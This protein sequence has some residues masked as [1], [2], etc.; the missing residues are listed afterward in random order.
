[1]KRFFEFLDKFLLN[2]F[3]KNV[4]KMPERFIKIIAYYHPDPYIRKIYYEKL[5]VIMGENT[6]ANLG[7]TVVR[8]KNR[9]CVIIGANVSIAPNVTIITDSNPNNGKEIYNFSYTKEKLCKS[10]NVIIEDEAWIGANVIIFPGVKIGRCSII[11]AGSIVMND[12]EPY[13][14][15]AGIPAKKIRDLRTGGKIN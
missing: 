15:Y 1:M 7:L 10:G 8:N 12:T 6:L 14:I 5:G 4:N 9:P 3:K 11:G 13:C 2:F